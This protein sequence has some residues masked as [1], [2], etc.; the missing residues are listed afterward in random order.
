MIWATRGGRSGLAVLAIVWA[1]VLVLVGGLHL[2]LN[3]QE[4]LARRA[5]LQV[6]HLPV[7]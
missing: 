3:Q 7:T 4:I 6:G 5:S 1:A 2:R